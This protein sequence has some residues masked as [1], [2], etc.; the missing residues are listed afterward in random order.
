MNL[1]F[2][3]AAA[4]LACA[5]IPAFAQQIPYAA[6]DLVVAF[7]NGGS[8]DF[9]INLGLAT[10]L[11][12]GNGATLD[13]GNVTTGLTAAGQTVSNTAWGVV[14]AQNGASPYNT[15][16]SITNGTGGTVT[17]ANDAI[18]TTSSSGTP[19]LA[20]QPATSTGFPA[21]QIQGTGSD[22]SNLVSGGTVISTVFAT[23]NGATTT[24]GVTVSTTGDAN[25]FAN[26]SDYDN[27]NS[28]YLTTT[29]AGSAQLW[30][31][32][33]S[34]PGGTG[35]GAANAGP[36]NAYFDLGTFSLSSTGELTFTAIPEPSTYAAI[37]GA[38]TICVVALRR[39]SV[40]SA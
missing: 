25:S 12:N 37:L 36:L 1:K 14:A 33:S 28:S 21:G 15:T 9:E 3:S 23:T 10:N 38:L 16:L 39:R 19:V 2:L 32:A 34:T 22:I 18:W 35:K 5:S 20:N 8:T 29:G 13:F 6:N 17:V 31:L 4:A 7:D 24:K 40:L 26:T 30:V 11:P 27:L